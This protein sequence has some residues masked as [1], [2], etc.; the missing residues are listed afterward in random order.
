LPSTVQYGTEELHRNVG[1]GSLSIWMRHI[2]GSTWHQKWNGTAATNDVSGKWKGNAVT[3]GSGM[4]WGQI[5]GEAAKKQLMVVSGAEPSV[6][7]GGGWL[8]GGY[9][10]NNTF[11]NLV[12]Y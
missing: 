2:T 8:L 5:T 6:G 11:N 7:A 4:T 9:V 3:Y 10:V 12:P 1:Y